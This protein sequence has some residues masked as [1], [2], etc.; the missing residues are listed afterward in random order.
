MGI[1]EE[2]ILSDTYD[3]ADAFRPEADS[4]YIYHTSGEERS[5]HVASWAQNAQTVT[6]I[7]VQEERETEIAV[8]LRGDTLPIQ[9]RSERQFNEL[10][11]RTP[12]KFIYIDVTGLSHHVWAPLLRSAL[13]AKRD[14]MVVYVEPAQYR[15]DAAPTEGQVFDLSERIRGIAPLPGFA[16]LADHQGSDTLFVPLLGFEGRRLAHLLEQVQPAADKIV[17][18]VG[19]PGFRPEYPFHTYQGNLRALT[20]T[21]AWQQVE[22]VTASCPFGVFFLLERLAMEH[23][24]EVIKIA[25]IGTKPHAVGAVL[26]RIISKHRVELVYDHPI[27]KSSRTSGSDKLHVYHVSALCAGRS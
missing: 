19:V 26:F 23:P 18:V 16:S 13:N 6:L 4:V 8:S 10:W 17:P 22:Y 9:L 14:V 15:Y 11:N 27:R 25:P 21:G 1:P 20:T 12:C 24:R 5:A 3:R 2:P 7:E